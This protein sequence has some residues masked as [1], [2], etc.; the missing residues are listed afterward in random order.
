MINM[1]ICQMINAI[2][3]QMIYAIICQ[4]IDMII[5]QMINAIICQMMNAIICQMNAVSNAKSTFGYLLR[6]EI[7]LDNLASKNEWYDIS[8][9]DPLSLL[10]VAGA[11]WVRAAGPGWVRASGGTRRQWLLAQAT[12]PQAMA[13]SPRPGTRQWPRAA[14]RF[15]RLTMQAA[16]AVVLAKRWPYVRGVEMAVTKL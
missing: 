6:G 1:I 13:V 10:P 15:G 2:I 8:L 4:M 12:G 16:M 11:G 5:C 9:R 7:W 3:C 14:G